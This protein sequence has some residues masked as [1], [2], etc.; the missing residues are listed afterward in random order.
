M[1]CLPSDA[2]QE[3]IRRLVIAWNELMAQERYGDALEMAPTDDEH[4]WT[5]EL[6]ESAVYTYGCPG[7][8]REEAIKE[9]GRADYRI[10]SV[11]ENPDKDAIINSIL[12]TP[13]YQW[14]GKQDIAV[15]H[16][17]NVPLNGSMSDLTAIFSARKTENHKIE[18]I[19]HDLH[20]M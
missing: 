10:T 16:Y 9:F 2:D 4:H 20:V 19:F 11:L 17:D 8:T 1:R 3:E 5:P 14:M 13:A 6:L 18:L 12:I 15:I 7:M